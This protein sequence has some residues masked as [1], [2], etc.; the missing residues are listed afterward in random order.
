M[1]F[2]IVS[3]LFIA[4]S[5]LGCSGSTSDTKETTIPAEGPVNELP[6][7]VVTLLNGTNVDMKGLNDKA[8]LV[9]FRPDCDHCQREAM[10][11]EENLDAFANNSIYFITSD[12]M[13]EIERFANDYKLTGHSNV[14]FGWTSVENVLTNFGSVSTPSIYIYSREHKLIKSFNGEVDINQVLAFL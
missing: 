6:N 1:A 11:I 3:A 5:L 4:G 7:M 9:V 10:A 13:P 8:I 2:R 12:P 14:F